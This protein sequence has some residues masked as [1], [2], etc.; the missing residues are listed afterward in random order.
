MKKTV[1]S[2]QRNISAR[3]SYFLWVQI[4]GPIKRLEI[5]QMFV[6]VAFF[7]TNS[8]GCFLRNLLP[9]DLVASNRHEVSFVVLVE[10]SELVVQVDWGLQS[11]RSG[12]IDGTRGIGHTRGVI[13]VLDVNV[14]LGIVEGSEGRGK[15]QENQG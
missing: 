8:F 5:I 6:L 2:S 13:G 3:V 11:G 4:S 10:L 9:F 7:P 14:A 15:C 12:E 1:E